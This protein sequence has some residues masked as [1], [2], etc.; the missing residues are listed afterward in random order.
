MGD[1]LSPVILF[2]VDDA[3]IVKIGYYSGYSG[4]VQRTNKHDQDVTEILLPRMW[5]K[6]SFRSSPQLSSSRCLS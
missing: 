2:L 6:K 3:M 4:E 1:F 5:L